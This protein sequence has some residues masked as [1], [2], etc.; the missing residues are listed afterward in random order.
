MQRKRVAHRVVS[1]ESDQESADDDPSLPGGL[2]ESAVTDF[3]EP[4]AR[5]TEISYSRVTGQDEDEEE[6]E[7]QDE[8]ENKEGCKS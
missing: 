8:D 6:Q 7:E 3:D 5:G 4:N 1:D 2:P